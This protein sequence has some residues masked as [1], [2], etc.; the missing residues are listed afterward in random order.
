MRW[1]G[2]GILA[3]LVLAGAG[4]YA[5]QWHTMVGMFDAIESRGLPV[6]GY[7]RAVSV[8]VDTYQ[9]WPRANEIVLPAPPRQGV[10]RSV[11]LGEKGALFFELS[12]WTLKGRTTLTMAPVVQSS[13]LLP[14]N[15]RLTY[16][17]IAANPPALEQGV[18]GDLEMSSL[19]D[20][21]KL[22]TNV[23]EKWKTDRWRIA[24]PNP[25]P[26]ATSP[27]VME[28]EIEDQCKRII[29]QGTA[30][31]VPCLSR[32]DPAKAE[33]LQSLL[34]G[35]MFR[36]FPSLAPPASAG[37]GAAAEL[38]KKT[39]SECIQLWNQLA[40]QLPEA[41]ECFARGGDFTH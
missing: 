1:K 16:D 41:K 11:R 40:A 6:A 39:N 36:P 31:W 15:G 37:P 38:R 9:R 2:Q 23:F 5:W 13:A 30:E 33:K 35:G 24:H 8:F 20:I 28:P 17:C 27:P 32:I 12:G 25:L 14:P 26:V 4:A 7:T 22:N 21:A 10:V 29:T 18:C 34:V 3:A 19:A